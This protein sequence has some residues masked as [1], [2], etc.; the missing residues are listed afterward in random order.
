MRSKERTLLPS[1]A[2]SRLEH[3]K[4]RFL[5]DLKNKEDYIKFM[6]EVLYRCDTEEAPASA[7]EEGVRC[8]VP[9]H[10]VYHPKEKKRSGSNMIGQH[11]S[12]TFKETSLNNQLLSG[13]HLTNRLMG[14]LCKL[15]K[16]P[17]A[18]ACDVQM[19]QQS[20]ACKNDRVLAISVVAKW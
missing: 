17:Y 8:Y 16:Y 12:A 19:F 3:L 4:K 10:V 13:P 18:I 2:Q 11:S 14:V 9:Y 15:K 5:R 1:V 6:N 7:H 20:F